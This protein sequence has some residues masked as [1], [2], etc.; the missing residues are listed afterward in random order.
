MAILLISGSLNPQSRSRQLVREAE[1]VFAELGIPTDFL[2]LRDHPLPLCDGDAAYDDPALPGLE[3]RIAQ[4]EAVLVGV[5]IYNF[6]GNAAFKNLVELTGSDAWENQ[7]VGFLC[8]AGGKSSYMSVIGLANQLMLD[9]R[10]LVVPRFIYAV[11]SDFE[12]TPAGEPRIINAEIMTR[13]RRLCE[14][15]RQVM[16]GKLPPATV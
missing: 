3:S 4:A 11:Y 16:R 13:I 9:F 1:N 12:K 8:A 5:P 15:T 7:V 6:Y 10:C 14:E 2:D